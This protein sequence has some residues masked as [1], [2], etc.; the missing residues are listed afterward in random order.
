MTSMQTKRVLV[1]EDDSAIR[2]GLVDALKFTGY[3]VLQAADG[4]TGSISRRRRPLTCCCS[5]WCCRT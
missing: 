3:E 4:S 2:N 1:V 5:I